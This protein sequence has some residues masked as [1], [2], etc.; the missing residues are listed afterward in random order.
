MDSEEQEDEKVECP[1]CGEIF[2]NRTEEGIHRSEEHI[3]SGNTMSE[4]D[5][6]SGKGESIIDDWKKNN[7]KA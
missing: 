6:S 3:D 7:V 2:D 1:Y 4:S 5:T